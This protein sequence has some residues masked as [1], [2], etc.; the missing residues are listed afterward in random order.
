MAQLR[1]LSA[2]RLTVYVAQ[3]STPPALFGSEDDH[4]LEDIRNEMMFLLLF[5]ISI[6]VLL[7]QREDSENSKVSFISRTLF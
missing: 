4:F 5:F 2:A 1:S 3:C 7:D 6:L